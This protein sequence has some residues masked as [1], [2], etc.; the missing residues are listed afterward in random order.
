M[1]SLKERA[2]LK[3]ENNI[4]MDLKEVESATVTSFTGLR[5]GIIGGRLEVR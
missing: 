5:T 4:K 3:D 1:I 2:R